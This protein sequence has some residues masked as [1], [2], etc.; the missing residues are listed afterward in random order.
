MMEILKDDAA[1]P[2][3]NKLMNRDRIGVVEVADT[4]K[5]LIN[6]LHTTST[7]VRP[8]LNGSSQ[9]MVAEYLGL[10]KSMV[11]QYMSISN[12]RSNNVKQLLAIN[13]ANISKAY[14][15]SRIKGKTTQ[16]I[17]SLQLAEIGR[18]SPGND[19]LIHKIKTAQMVLKNVAGSKS[20]KF[21]EVNYHNPTSATNTIIE[22]IEKCISLIAPNIQ[23][24]KMLSEQLGYC[25]FLIAH[26]QC[27]CI[28]GSIIDH[29]YLL[30]QRRS[31]IDEILSVHDQVMSEKKYT[32]LLISTKKDLETAI[33]SDN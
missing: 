27:K 20:I 11:S 25:N 33:S 31:I 3:L 30:L 22:N 9:T 29:Q 7:P 26:E 21:D 4:M 28:C 6:T 19:K 16:E 23:K 15:I 17:E 14:Y 8:Q 13:R 18:I 32:S 5:K 10:S 2:F 12:I 1:S 24:V